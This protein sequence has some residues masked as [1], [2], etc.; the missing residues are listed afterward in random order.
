LSDRSRHVFEQLPECHTEPV[1]KKDAIRMLVRP[2]LAMQSKGSTLA[3]I[4][5]LLSE[6]GIAM[7]ALVLR[8]YL[9]K[10]MASAAHKNR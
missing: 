5:A 3:A 6:R 7:T 1:T 9:A 8:N 2:I 4:A 10:A